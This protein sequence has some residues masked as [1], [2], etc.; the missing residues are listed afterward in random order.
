M[1]PVADRKNRIRPWKGAEW[2]VASPPPVCGN[3]S[4]HRSLPRP[5]PVGFPNARFFVR[6]T[7][8]R[9]KDYSFAPLS[10]R[11]P[12]AHEASGGLFLSRTGRLPCP[13]PHSER[14]GASTCPGDYRINRGR[15]TAWSF[16][17]RRRSSR[18]APG[19][20]RTELEGVLKH[21]SKGSN[22]P[23]NPGGKTA[24]IDLSQVGFNGQTTRFSTGISDTS[25]VSEP[26]S[27]HNYLHPS[28]LFQHSRFVQA[29]Q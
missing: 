16:S 27:F 9:D 11:P 2:L 8:K 28:K 20:C 25:L 12:I 22:F 18:P 21:S 15:I 7:C 13:L 14:S 26:L 10:F 6:L 5:N 4:R 17:L 19:F 3:G 29:G 23:R 1:R 24:S